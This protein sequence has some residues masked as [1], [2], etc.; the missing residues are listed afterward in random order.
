MQNVNL[1]LETIDVSNESGPVDE[2]VTLDEMKN[3]LKLIGFID[4]NDSTSVPEFT[5]DD[6][7]ITELI[8]TARQWLE[9]ELGISIVDHDW[10]AIGVTNEAGMIQLKKGPVKEISGIT[11][12][13]GDDID[14]DEIKVI[15]DFLKCPRQCDMTVNYSAGFT[16]IPSP[17]VTEIKRIA[18]YLYQHRGEEDE[19]KGYEITESALKYS[20]KPWL[21]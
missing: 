2:P 8:T 1:I 6:D 14:A 16:N 4:D 21:E 13:D 10:Q 9:E 7:I 19:L 3:Y 20:R 15:G 18:S 17:L 11:D 5:D 12:K